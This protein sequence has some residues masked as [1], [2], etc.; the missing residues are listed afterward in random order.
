M[1]RR[2]IFTACVAV[3]AIGIAAGRVA[4]ASAGARLDYRGAVLGERVVSR[5]FD[6]ALAS[7]A[8]HRGD[9]RALGE[10]V[11]RLQGLGYT[12]ASASA[13]WSDAGAQRLIVDAIEGPRE[14]ASPR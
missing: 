14:R 2:L 11:T 10:L 3:L 8:R 12:A 7:A 1:R 4:P 13:H 6:R 9:P 5:W